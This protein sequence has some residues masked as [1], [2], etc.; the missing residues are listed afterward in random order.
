MR[1]LFSFTLFFV[2]WSTIG[3]T[4]VEAKQVPYNTVV[5]VGNMPTSPHDSPTF[6]T[7]QDLNEYYD[8]AD[9]GCDEECLSAKWM[10]LT[11]HA[12]AAFLSVGYH[13]TVLEVN[14]TASNH[15]VCL[16]PFNDSNGSRKV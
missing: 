2:L 16:I 11:K 14:S 3:A 8:L 5:S 6:A 13:V 15:K 1:A 4:V 10:E 9:N 12:D 7:V